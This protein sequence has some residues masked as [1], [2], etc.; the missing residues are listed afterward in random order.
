MSPRANNEYY[1]EIDVLMIDEDIGS[2]ENESDW[3]DDMVCVWCGEA[4]LECIVWDWKGDP[5]N[6]CVDCLMEVGEAC[7]VCDMFMTVEGFEEGGDECSVCREN[8]GLN[9][10]HKADAEAHNDCEDSDVEINEED[11]ELIR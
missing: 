9:D 7:P 4:E 2:D 10:I 5:H 6:T 11:L 8:R 1:N 3:D